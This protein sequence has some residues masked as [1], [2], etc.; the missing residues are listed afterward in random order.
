MTLDLSK[1]DQAM[2]ELNK[3]EILDFSVL[4]NSAG[5]GNRNTH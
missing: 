4:V 2:E 1:L 3:L 5:I